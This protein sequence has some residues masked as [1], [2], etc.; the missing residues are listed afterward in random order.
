MAVIIAIIPLQFFQTSILM[1]AMN[2]MPIKKGNVSIS[3]TVSYV[4]Q[5]PW[6]FSGSIRQNI[7][8]GRDFEKDKFEDVIDACS[9]REV[10]V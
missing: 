6:I 4:S 5:E 1:A 9:L 2:E 10:C 3:G 8:F 7:L